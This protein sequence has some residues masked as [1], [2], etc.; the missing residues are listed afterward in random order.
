[1]YIK[2]TLIQNIKYSNLKLEPEF[3]L[4]TPLIISWCVMQNSLPGNSKVAMTAAFECV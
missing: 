3:P 2:C 4:R 1:M